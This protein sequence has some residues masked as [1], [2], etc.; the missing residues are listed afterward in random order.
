MKK[1]IV[2]D[3]ELSS[4]QKI[5]SVLID[6]FDLSVCMFKEEPL[7][8]IE[9]VKNNNVS[10][11]FLDINMPLINGIELAEKLISI[12]PNIKIIFI[13]GYV[14]DKNYIIN[15]FKN[16]LLDILSKPFTK[17]EFQ[18]II[19][20]INNDTNKYFLHTFGNFDLMINNIPINFYSKKSKEL[21]ALLVD[22]NGSNVPMEEA[23]CAMWPD[24]D[25][26]KS[27]ILYRDAVWK[28]R[29]TLKE[30]NLENLVSFQRALLHINKIIAC[31]YWEMLKG[32]KNL[33]K[34]LYL[35]SY[36]WSLETQNYLSNLREI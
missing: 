1:I 22:R 13:T 34:G 35:T 31:D 3:D 2:V 25:I 16:N 18:N 14:F 23:I 26:D 19:E 11:A 33:Y 36:E 7:S 27:K 5:I 29:K 32:C 28:L 4:I 12:D 20:K 24:I 10:A 9:Y 21:L 8:S 6:Q 15:K 30:N 17:N